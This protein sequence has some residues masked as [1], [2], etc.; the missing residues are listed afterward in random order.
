M[1]FR[2]MSP[3][4]RTSSEIVS[5]SAPANPM[6]TWPFVQAMQETGHQAC[7]LG[8]YDSE[9]WHSATI[10]YLRSGRLNR[11]LDVLSLPDLPNPEPFWTGLLDYCG[12]RRISNLSIQSFSSNAVVL[13]ALKGELSRQQRTEFALDLINAVDLMAC[14]SVGHRRNVR[15]GEKAGLTVRRTR[16]RGFCADHL[17]VSEASMERRR[18]RGE[19]VGLSGDSFLR[20]A[21][22]SG[23]AEL[24]QALLDSRVVASIAVLLA[25]RGGYLQSSGADAEGMKI[26]AS[27][28]LNFQIAKALQTEGRDVY[29]FGG[30]TDEQAGLKAYKAHFG[31]RVIDL[32]AAEFF[33]GPKWKSKLTSAVKLLTR[34]PLRPGESET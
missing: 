7:I 28:F 4:D 13:P 15:R 34:K 16:D 32:E 19:D 5:L 14:M 1:T 24:F 9:Q 26:G 12:R 10:G 11:S 23:A 29:N 21:L 27:H 2:V 3:V 31:G 33:V 6:I 22:Q 8:L 25:P 17:R 18:G 30:C 20:A